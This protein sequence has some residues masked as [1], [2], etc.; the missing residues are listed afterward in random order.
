VVG[1]N[2]QS[3]KSTIMM[4]SINDLNRMQVEFSEVYENMFDE[5]YKRLEVA[6]KEKLNAMQECSKQM[7]LLIDEDMYGINTNLGRNVK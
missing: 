3:S 4:L 7:Q 5:S 1:D 6:L 2:E